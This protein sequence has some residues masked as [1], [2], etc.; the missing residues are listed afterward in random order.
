MV[1]EPLLG[2]R[3]EV[4]V[5]NLG[6]IGGLKCGTEKDDYDQCMQELLRNRKAGLFQPQSND[7]SHPAISR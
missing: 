3:A 7:V 2:G 5:G 1:D 4:C 6:N